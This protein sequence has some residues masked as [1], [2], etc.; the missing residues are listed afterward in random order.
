MRSECNRLLRIRTTVASAILVT[1]AFSYPGVGA[2]Q[3]TGLGCTW[4]EDTPN[5][6]R[7]AVYFNPGTLASNGFSV[8]RFRSAL[9]QSLAVW[10][11]E[12]TSQ[13]DLFYAGDTTSTSGIA[14]AVVVNHQNVWTCLDNAF[15]KAFWAPSGDCRSSS[16]GPIVHVILRDSCTNAVR[17]WRTT[18][19]GPA[20]S[21]GIHYESVMVHEIGHTLSMPDVV[22]ATGVMNAT[23]GEHAA[24]LHLYP[25]DMAS[26]QIT[27]DGWTQ[28]RPRTAL[29]SNNGVTFGASSVVPLGF[30]ATSPS[31][32]P[33]ADVGLR[34]GVF[35]MVFGQGVTRRG[36][37]GSWSV[38]DQPPNAGVG[39]VNH[40]VSTAHSDF[41]ETLYAWPTGCNRTAHCAIA[42]AWTSSNGPPWTTGTL[43]AAGTYGRVELAYDA[44]RDRFVMAYID[45]DSSRIFM[46][47]TPAVAP[48]WSTP[49]LASQASTSITETFRYMGGIV[50]DSA[51]A[52]LLVAGTNTNY[53][54]S[55]EAGQIVQ[56]ATSFS[57]G[58][59]TLGWASWASGGAPANYITRRHFGL[60]RNPGGT[61]V[62]AWRGPSAARSLATASKTGILPSTAFGTVSEP[63]LDVSNSVDI[64]WTSATANF[65][66]GYSAP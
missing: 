28:R 40:W 23:A 14:N 47:S 36:T 55:P 5:S 50:F 58:T 3:Y 22:T 35:E 46:S 57:S 13:V 2:A 48:S 62:M 27:T 16:A 18:W 11:E 45:G 59:Y 20:G 4:S 42:W 31:L 15:A 60:A 43:A 24:N 37:H 1:C 63:V 52:G 21:G 51:G 25:I 33:A 39:A 30:S 64:A 66:A 10:N 54:G 61:V 56:M 7:V 32:S 65:A 53:T 8:A 38:I 44:F 19:P 41:G 34:S 12:S 29:S 26:A 17:N 9:I 49:A 6:T